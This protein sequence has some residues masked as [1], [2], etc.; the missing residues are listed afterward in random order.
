MDAG[1]EPLADKCAI[2]SNIIGTETGRRVGKPTRHVNLPI[3]SKR[4]HNGS[5]MMELRRPAAACLKIP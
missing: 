2:K 3:S 5:L 1:A 4:A